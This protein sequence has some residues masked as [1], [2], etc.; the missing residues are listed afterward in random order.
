[1][2]RFSGALRV[3]IR[4]AV[5]R[6]WAVAL[7]A[8]A[9][10]VAGFWFARQLRIDT[11]FANLVPRDYPSV[12]ALEA[13]RETVGSEA[14]VDVAIQSPSFEANKAFA[15]ALIPRALALAPSPGAEPY[16]RRVDF[17]KDTAFLEENAL[18]FATYA[19]LDS[20]ESY[21]RDQIREAKLEANPFFFDL[22]DDEDASGDDA[23]DPAQD[24]QEVYDH[25]VGK[26]YPVN[27]DSTIMAL[28]FYPGGS[29]TDIGFIQTLYDDLDALVAEL[30]PSS[31]HP[32]MQVVP[33]GRLLRQLV[34]LRTISD[35]VLGSFAAG[36]TAVLLLVVGYFFYKGYA[37]RA[38]H[39]FS[40]RALVTQLARTPVLACLI[41][42]PLLM[43]LSWTLGVAWLA[44]G[45]LNLM[46]S[47]LGLVLFGLGIDYGIHFYARYAEERS[48]GHAAAE[49]AEITFMSTGKAIALG[50]FTT[51][52]ALYVLSAADFRGFSEFGFIAGTGILFAVG[53]MTIVMPALLALCERY[54]LLDFSG[55]EAEGGDR[56]V[57]QTRRKYGRMPG[58]RG[59]ALG[60]AVLVVAA[61]ALLPR[62]GFQY[63]FGA[64][65]PE[66][67]A[68]DAK[69][70][71]IR[72]VYPSR[73]RNPAYVLVDDP[74]EA[75]AV[76]EA[77][78]RHA[79]ADT[80]SPTIDRV[81]TLQERF[82]MAPAEQRR[83][84]DRIAGIRDLF[85]DPFL[86]VEDDEGLARAKRAAGT[87]QPLALEQLPESLRNR[88]LSK[89]GELGGFVV[90]YP[91]VGLAD[92]RASMAFADDVGRIVTG[93]GNAYHAGSP[94]IVAADM[95]RLMR[96]DAPWM[97][98]GALLMVILLMWINFRSLRWVALATA[99][100][101][102]GVLWMLLVMEA[103]GLQLNFYNMIVLPAILGIGNDAGVHLIHRYREEG[104]GSI[105]HVLR[106]TGEHIAMGSFTT[107]I[108]FAGLLL[109]FHPGLHS[110]GELAVVG[111][112]STLLAALLFSPAALQWLEDRQ[113]SPAVESSAS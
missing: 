79:R 81:E 67:E 20:L 100:L 70:N 90:I 22:G 27:E 47:T 25:I 69:R 34:E 17:E 13:L 92:G 29:Q 106:Y 87:V 86:S 49:A 112:G 84:L 91:S 8:L 7:L 33:A 71:L 35:D 80:L 24:L 76:Q 42:I 10:S 77:L 58:A 65:E 103:A 2:S 73:G 55:I 37:A 108:G 85:S 11:D 105:L 44:F 78:E 97:M 36:A 66:Y 93:D 60:S 3:F 21:L 23:Y 62:V 98:A 95:L 101:I 52:A 111:I 72:E 9:L 113:A 43:S 107:M 26:R 63:D 14:T 59:L 110:I 41:G 6:A 16:L 61:L 18:Y 39:R 57:R 68:Y 46:T 64:L 45:M 53:A 38:G 48:E 31:W 83:K 54:R 28:R 51:A 4:L 15:E 74:S 89:T 12:Q 40:R 30:D 102:V 96:R 50:A 56:P 104:P 32:D 75:P 82:P 88:F 99:P 94:S 109:S 19:E 5:R 1:M